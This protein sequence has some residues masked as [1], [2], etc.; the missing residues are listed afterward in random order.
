[1]FG[2]RK[3]KKEQGE[4]EKQPE[5]SE[6][7]EQSEE[8][9]SEEDEQEQGQQ[10]QMQELSNNNVSSF[11]YTIFATTANVVM[12]GA[13][14][15]GAPHIVVAAVICRGMVARQRAGEQE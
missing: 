8:E 6:Q 12:I 2:Y 11:S 9:Q 5:Q 3:F 14:C 15:L 13:L 10:Q 4:E 7:S 1:M